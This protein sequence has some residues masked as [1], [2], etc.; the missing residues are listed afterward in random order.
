MI[1]FPSNASQVESW[2]N[3]VSL[4][5]SQR[6]TVTFSDNAEVDR[7]ISATFPGTAGT[8]AAT[9]SHLGPSAGPI[10]A[11]FPAAV[12]SLSA[13][14][15]KRGTSSKG[16]AATFPGASGT[17]SAAVTRIENV[18]AEEGQT[19]SLDTGFDRTNFEWS[20]SVEV[21]AVYVAGGAT[22][23][24]RFIRLQGTSFHIR[25][26]LE[27][28]D[29]N[30]L[31]PDFTDVVE[32]Y[33]RAF[34]LTSSNGMSVVI[35]GPNYSGNIYPS[36][37][38]PD[39]EDPYFYTPA[40]GAEIATWFG[41][42]G[43]SDT[44]T[45][46]ISNG[47]AAPPSDMVRP[48]A[49]TFPSEASSLAITVSRSLS[50]AVAR[51][52]A[53]TFTSE[54]SALAITVSRS[55]ATTV[56]RSIAATFPSEDSSLSAVIS[57]ATSAIVI[58][59]ET[60]MVR[61]HQIVEDRNR[62]VLDGKKYK[63]KGN[64][65]QQLASEYPPRL[66]FGESRRAIR[67]RTDALAMTDFRGGIGKEFVE[68]DRDAER[69]WESTF[70]HGYQG[71]LVFPPSV[72]SFTAPT[73]SGGHIEAIVGFKNDIY[74]W[75][76]RKVYRWKPATGWS[77]ALETFDG[78]LYTMAV[79]S[80]GEN[81]YIIISHSE[82][83]AFTTDGST[84]EDNVTIRDTSGDVDLPA[85]ITTP[86]ALTWNET[87]SQYLIANSNSNIIYRMTAAGAITGSIITVADAT[88]I[89]GIATSADRRFVLVEE[90]DGYKIAVY[91]TSYVRQTAEELDLPDGVVGR[92]IVV[93]ND[94]IYIGDNS[95][96]RML[97]Y[98]F[99]TTGFTRQAQL[100]WS[101]RTNT[102][103]A[104]FQSSRIRGN[105]Q[106]GWSEWSAT[107]WTRL[108]ITTGAGLGSKTVDAIDDGSTLRGTIAYDA[109]TGV[110]YR[111]RDGGT[112]YPN[113]LLSYGAEAFVQSTT[114]IELARP[115]SDLQR[116][117]FYD[118]AVY[119]IFIDYSV[120]TAYIQNLGP[121]NPNTSAV[122]L[123]VG[124]I[125]LQEFGGSS[126]NANGR[127]YSVFIAAGI[128][129]IP[130]NTR[131]L[132][133]WNLDGSRNTGADSGAAIALP[134]TAGIGATVGLHLTASATHIALIR[135]RTFALGPGFAPNTR[136]YTYATSIYSIEQGLTQNTSLGF[137]FDGENTDIQGL[138]FTDDKIVALDAT[139]LSLF[140]YTDTGTSLPAERVSIPAVIAEAG[141]V[142]VRGDY[143]YIASAADPERLYRQ[144]QTVAEQTQ[145][146]NMVTWNDKI[147]GI[148][149][150]G[151]LR[152]I[153]SLGSSDTWQDEGKIPSHLTPVTNL[154]VYASSVQQADAIYAITTTGVFEYDAA[155]QRFN[156]TLVEF[157][158]DQNAGLG[159]AVWQGDLY[160]SVGLSTYRIGGGA[161]SVVDLVGWER[162]D[163]S[164]FEGR[165]VQLLAT[166]N[167]LLALV[168]P[169]VA[170]GDS[171]IMAYN[172]VAWWA[173]RKLDGSHSHTMW[174]GDHAGG[175]YLYMN[176]SD[177]LTRLSYPRGIINPSI[178]T[179][180]EY[181]DVA[182]AIT[183]WFRAAEPDID[184]VALNLR[185]EIHGGA[186]DESRYVEVD[187][188]M[189]SEDDDGTT[190]REVTWRDKDGNEDTRLDDGY[191][192]SL[193]SYTADDIERNGVSFRAIRF[194]IRGTR[195]AD[196]TK[197]PDLQA[198]VLEYVKTQLK[199]WAYTVTIDLDSDFEG[200][201]P[202][203]MRQELVA[204]SG[205]SFLVSFNYLSNPEAGSYVRLE[206]PQSSLLS[207]RNT[208][209]TEIVT[210]IEL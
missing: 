64:V 46:T 45:F 29:P 80:K 125:N 178:L 77:D 30:T 23:Y 73:D 39:V 92:G 210:L 34:T 188:Q 11:T 130:D 41:A 157:A 187:Y 154:I 153:L 120:N 179:T 115:V 116:L 151:Q 85:Q 198:L 72:R 143:F 19:I 7:P 96:N 74:A 81:E 132:R 111:Y 84:W 137:T 9:V 104:S 100:E 66:V 75:Q 149:P 36:E 165:I 193:F 17:L 99:S 108:N 103:D 58:P 204:L 87:D 78:D 105:G 117:W 167:Y 82:G 155:N 27:G 15:T 14:I 139:A 123:A 107:F 160:I 180:N 68:V 13:T 146:A 24:L 166:D 83:F 197:F 48:I 152:S 101:T 98:E 3:H 76:N 126:L 28:A 119:A 114:E 32:E 170:G 181:A 10:V 171:Y 175:Y 93:V 118:G 16:I 164:P 109:G 52:I 90:S 127:G 22:A 110:L 43:A 37:D 2:T 145:F 50:T 147:W 128:I 86:G 8:L 1:G 172:R 60:Q 112:T 206:R 65:I 89:H 174:V 21:D 148:T 205:E 185:A 159:V 162:D 209:G 102:Q 71:H 49:A 189:R 156:L 40:N 70:N 124:G 182:E 142:T 62:V 202:E 38:D 200:R 136:G 55:P 169:L 97:A 69:L 168:Q 18:P 113:T 134:T 51:S 129:Y 199:K 135:T 25:L 56:Y 54:T 141:G 20:G 44:I 201:T 26:S 208:E 106:D 196:I 42:V 177:V 191:H 163:G 131:I 33:E 144:P 122:Q 94:T 140:R 133:A 91:N 6:L 67:S 173:L 195:G 121:D 194:R 203:Q 12:G 47:M 79:V 4:L 190:W 161:T 57:V 5:S 186:L 88:G 207:G 150:N 53:A 59:G 63:T 183:P 184:K 35:A 31:G 158:K 192:E 61:A 138:T 95:A 176:D